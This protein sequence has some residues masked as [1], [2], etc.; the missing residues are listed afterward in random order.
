MKFIPRR[1]RTVRQTCHL[2]VALLAG[3]FLVSCGS[4]SKS[5]ELA[6]ESVG[7]FHA[8]LDTEQYG[9][10]Y[11]ATDEKFRSAT[12]EADFA[13]ILQAVHNKLGTVRDSNLRNTG[14]AWF[15]G[16]GATVTL[17]YD[18]KFSDGTGSEQFVWHIKDNQASLYSYHI[19][20]NDLIAK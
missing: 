14:V 5:I 1:E 16:Q 8:Q 19:N 13:K 10:I 9:S 18:T 6:K 7:L 20:S 11:S 15:A 2:L 3:C 12:T 17:V 4:S